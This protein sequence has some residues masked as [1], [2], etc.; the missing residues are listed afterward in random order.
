MK[1]H[2][3]TALVIFGV[4]LSSMAQSRHVTLMTIPSETSSFQ[5][6]GL[7][8]AAGETAELVS[9][10]VE[11]NNLRLCGVDVKIQDKNFYDMFNLNDNPRRP[12]IVSG[13]A[14][15]DVHCYGYKALFTFKITSEAFPVDRTLV[16]SSDSPGA[17]ISLQVSTDL[18]NWTAT[19]NGLYTGTNGAKFFRIRADRVQ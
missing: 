15:I 6:N 19:T 7:S 4:C 2:V 10:G 12:V 5:T 3:I 14:V 18:V 16:L 9:V 11:L 8:I 17:N 1:K 13:P